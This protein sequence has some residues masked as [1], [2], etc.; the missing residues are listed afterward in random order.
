MKIK[1]DFVT[2]SSS[3]SFIVAFDKPI[4]KIEDLSGIESYKATTVLN[5]C[6]NQEIRKLNEENIGTLFELF[7]SGEVLF[8]KNYFPNKLKKKYSFIYSSKYKHFEEEI[9]HEFKIEDEKILRAYCD[10]R[11]IQEEIFNNFLLIDIARKFIE[12]NKEKYFY[13][14]NY[15]DEGG[16]FFSEMEHGNTFSNYEHLQISQH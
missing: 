4:K 3:S 8:N 13:I 16:E 12:K 15:S 11:E 10:I 9:N 7:L 1:T 14:F 5:D 6:L 2:N